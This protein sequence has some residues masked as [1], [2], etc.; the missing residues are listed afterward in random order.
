MPTF[1]ENI[2]IDIDITASEFLD[3]CFDD[4]I[5]ELIDELE[6]RGYLK[7]PIRTKPEDNSFDDS[8]WSK[9]IN[10]LSNPF[11][12]LKLSNEDIETIKTITDKL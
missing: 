8:E 2:D 9:M 12:R 11:A 5:E 4:D 6:Y 3:E 1:N 7:N 10:I